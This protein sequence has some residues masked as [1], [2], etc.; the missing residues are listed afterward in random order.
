MD[1][2]KIIGIVFLIIAIFL[3]MTP[4]TNYCD[5]L[6]KINVM[7]CPKPVMQFVFAIIAFIIAIYLTQYEELKGMGV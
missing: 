2:K 5:T 7:D 1:T 6:T 3:G 4:Y